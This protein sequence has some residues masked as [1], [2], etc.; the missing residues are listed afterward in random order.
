M[1][2]QATEPVYIPVLAWC[3]ENRHIVHVAIDSSGNVVDV[4]SECPK[5]APC[6][7][8][9][10]GLSRSFARDYRQVWRTLKHL[11][12]AGDVAVNQ[13][14]TQTVGQIV[15]VIQ[16]FLHSDYP[17]DERESI[18]VAAIKAL[19]EIRDA[20]AAEALIE[21]LRDENPGIQKAT[22]A[23]LIH[24]GSPAVPSLIGVLSADADC[25]ARRE[26]AHALGEIGDKRAVPA[27][28]DALLKDPETDV[29]EA[30]AMALGRFGDT[31]DVVGSLILALQNDNSGDVRRAAAGSLAGFWSR[32]EVTMAIIQA[33]RKDN[34]PLVR[35]AAAEALGQIAGSLNRLD[36]DRSQAINAL[37]QA[38]REDGSHLVR[39]AAIRALVRGTDDTTRVIEALAHALLEDKDVFVRGTAVKLLGEI[40]N[41]HARAVLEQAW[42]LETNSYV[43]EAIRKALD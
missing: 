9:A 36:P 16:G 3:G 27:L 15:R 19:G 34:E 41:V 30:A 10:Y 38:S 42:A 11:A 23:A 4:R 28:I 12:W 14:D 43:R 40:G 6:Y 18:R 5:Q 13:G 31:R 20:R 33:L 22:A 25:Y 17:E 1:T 7:Q 2:Q 21:F 32:P 35:A 39:E 8:W 29:R 24:I 26:A 37:L